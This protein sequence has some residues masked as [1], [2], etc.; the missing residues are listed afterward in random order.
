[1]RLGVEGEEEIGVEGEED[2]GAEEK[3]GYWG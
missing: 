2:I 3:R 1:M